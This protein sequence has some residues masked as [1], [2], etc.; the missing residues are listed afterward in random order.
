MGELRL[1]ERFFKKYIAKIQI[2][3]FFFTKIGPS[4]HKTQNFRFYY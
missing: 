2:V 1:A 3:L 4:T